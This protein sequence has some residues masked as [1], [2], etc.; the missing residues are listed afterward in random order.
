MSLG[1]TVSVVITTCNRLGDLRRA[2]LSLVAQ[3]VLPDEVVVVDD[4]SDD[5]IDGSIFDIFPTSV[6][7]TLLVNDD[8]RG[9]NYCRNFGISKVTSELVLFLD[10]DDQFERGKIRVIRDEYL[11]DKFDVVYHPAIIIYMDYGI[12]YQSF[13]AE[14][15]DFLSLLCSNC[16]G[17]TSMVGVRLEFLQN[18][19]LFDER[20]PA[21][22][23]WD[24]WLSLAERSGAF[25]YIGVPLTRYYVKISEG[26]ISKSIDKQKAAIDLIDKKY[27]RWI[28]S[29]TSSQLKAR[30][31]NI[32]SLFFLKS[33][34]S[35]DRS[36]A[37]RYAL[38]GI[39]INRSFRSI[40]E[41]LSAVFGLR[42]SV[43]CRSYLQR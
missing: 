20:L 6:R 11:K 16:V 8:R 33:L 10:D 42:F 28:T 24:A 19:K 39:V 26:S 35:G 22:Q 5:H 36:S 2:L 37:F 25:K 18:N 43:W 9:A 12:S 34:L 23:D 40:F 7:C 14:N 21:L 15:I 29:L 1:L 31:G 3:E 30:N 27:S 13:P 41:L 32:N 4:K 38:K 17:A